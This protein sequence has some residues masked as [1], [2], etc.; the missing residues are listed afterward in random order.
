MS[1]IKKILVID[2]D[3]TCRVGIEASLKKMAFAEVISID[4]AMDAFDVLMDSK[5]NKKPVDLILCDFH[6][7]DVD[8]LSFYNGLRGDSD[9]RNIPFFIITENSE[10][11]NITKMIEAGVKNFLVKPISIDQLKKKISN[12]K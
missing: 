10:T 5:E 7:P 1:K 3:E 6:M 2:D 11:E 8:G 4:N 9:F 12:I